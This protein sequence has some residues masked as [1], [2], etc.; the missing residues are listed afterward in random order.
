M[1]RIGSVLIGEFWKVQ[2]RNGEARQERFG[3]DGYGKAIFGA[4]RRVSERKGRLG[5]D[6]YVGSYSGSGKAGMEQF[7][8]EGKGEVRQDWIG[9]VRF[10]IVRAR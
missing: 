5:L 9:S 8:M 6:C 3:E 10:V 7:V 2:V 4:S 1:D